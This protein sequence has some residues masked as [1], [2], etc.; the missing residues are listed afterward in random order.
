MRKLIYSV[1]KLGLYPR[2]RGT[3]KRKFKYFIALFPWIYPF[4]SRWFWN[5]IGGE[6]YYKKVTVSS[7]HLAVCQYILN[8]LDSLN[9]KNLLEVGCG[10]GNNLAS[11]Q[12]AYPDKIY[13]GCDFSLEQI[14]TARKHY[15]GIQFDIADARKLPYKDKTWD[16]VLVIG[17]LAH[18]P[19][20]HISECVQE[21]KRVTSG[22]LLVFEEDLK[23]L[24]EIYAYPTGWHFY[25][26][27]N[28]LFHDFKTEWVGNNS[29]NVHFP[30]Q[31]HVYRRG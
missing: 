28:K 29:P 14:R 8:G 4:V 7:R 20:K 18:I 10:T 30:L 11:L 26:N 5:Q 13:R 25:H 6:P 21:L 17:C 31:T 12:S 19:P 27:Y 3:H 15:E 23:F 16:I 24:P 1:F 22:Y 2:K 9:F